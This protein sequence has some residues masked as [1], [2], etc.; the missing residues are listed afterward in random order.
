MRNTKLSFHSPAPA[1]GTIIIII[2]KVKFEFMFLLCF[3]SSLWKWT[4]KFSLFVI[5]WIIFKN[6]SILKF[7]KKYVLNSQSIVKTSKFSNCVF[8]ITFSRWSN[9]RLLCSVDRATVSIGFFL[10]QEHAT[11]NFT[12]C[13]IRGFFFFLIFYNIITHTHT[14]QCASLYKNIRLSLYLIQFSLKIP[15]IDDVSW[16]LDGGNLKL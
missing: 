5:C 8:W 12:V 7:K 9:S 1:F 15:Q 3:C 14:A 6:Q 2:E 16:S 13:R 10:P 4:M 11:L